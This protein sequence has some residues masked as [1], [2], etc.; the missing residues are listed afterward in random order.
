MTD[1]SIDIVDRLGNPEEDRFRRF[2]LSV[3]Q[4]EPSG[5]SQQSQK[6]PSTS[7]SSQI[8]HEAVWAAMIVQPK[9]VNVQ[10]KEE[11]LRL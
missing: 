8:P 9:L 6:V 4:A 7:E 11:P 3:A 1:R 2:L 5:D 10:A